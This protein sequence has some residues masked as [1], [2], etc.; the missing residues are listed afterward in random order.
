MTEVSPLTPSPA[1]ALQREA[2]TWTHF[3]SR[4]LITAL[5][6]LPLTSCVTVGGERPTHEANLGPW[7]EA[8]PQLQLKIEQQ[9]QRL[10]WS[11]GIERIEIIQW[12][13]EVGEPAYPAMLEMVLDPRSDVAGAA[14]A[15]LGATRDARLVEP[16]RKLPWPEIDQPDL[17]LERAR[18]LLRLG[19][20]S[21]LP[22]LIE[23]LGD[24]RVM[25]RALCGQALLEAT[26]ERFGFDANAPIV[27]REASME[28]WWQ[29]WERRRQDPLR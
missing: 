21:M 26:H 22:H 23:G 8:S 27:E 3:M 1:Q 13:A 19:D 10:P 11:H 6:L 4:T 18:T 7:V 14:L 5:L 12:F 17:A 20:W 15:A 2:R 9:V 29:W 25:I 28:L 16:L 24:E